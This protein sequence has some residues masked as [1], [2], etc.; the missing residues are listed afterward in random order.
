MHMFC[1]CSLPSK[2]PVHVVAS[3]E[4]QRMLLTHSSPCSQVESLF[5]ETLSSDTISRFFLWCI[6]RPLFASYFSLDYVYMLDNYVSMQH[7]HVY[8]DLQLIYR[9][10]EMQERYSQMGLRQILNYFFSNIAHMSLP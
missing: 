9:Y 8:V 1:V 5:E 3:F 4:T 7:L 6:L 10:V 2:V